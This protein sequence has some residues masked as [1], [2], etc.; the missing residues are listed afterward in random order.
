MD[1]AEQS[2]FERLV[3]CHLDA[4]H[5]LA[6]YLTGDAADADDVVQETF[7]RALRHFHG[8]AGDDARAWLLVIVRNTS[9]DFLRKKMRGRF[10]SIDEV[11]D[12]A[13]SDDSH[14]TNVDQQLDWARVAQAMQ[15]LPLEFREVIVLREIEGLS[16][17]E[18][19]EITGIAAGTVMSRLSRAR[20][21]LKS[22][23]AQKQSAS[24]D[25]EAR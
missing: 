11:P 3:L 12:L 5:N 9:Y 1:P 17:A 2:R 14:A 24:S 4:A 16:Y 15:S 8:F 22:I 6:R 21:R 13:I 18:I 23:L 25:R 7:L 10:V 19:G 20:K